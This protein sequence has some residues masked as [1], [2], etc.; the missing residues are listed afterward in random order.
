MITKPDI[1]CRSGTATVQIAGQALSPSW[2]V[3]AAATEGA[4]A[5]KAAAGATGGA[6]AAA[7]AG[8]ATAITTR[9]EAARATI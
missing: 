3:A 1:S 9:A 8:T 7:A 2:G 4:A 6:A 5:A